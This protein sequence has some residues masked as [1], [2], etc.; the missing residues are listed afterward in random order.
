VIPSGT[1]GFS[2]FKRIAR[3]FWLLDLV[4]IEEGDMA[5]CVDVVGGVGR[6]QS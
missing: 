6:S 1:I 3:P 2:Q 5:G 4:W